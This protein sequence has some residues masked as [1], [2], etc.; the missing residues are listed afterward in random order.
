M[1]VDEEIELDGFDLPPWD[2]GEPPGGGPPRR[3][4]VGRVLP[5]LVLLFGVVALKQIALVTL[6]LL[7]APWDAWGVLLLFVGMVSGG[8]VLALLFA[9][10]WA[11][12]LR[13][14][15]GGGVSRSASQ[16]PRGPGPSARRPRA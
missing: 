15:A 5:W 6:P 14:G 16:P 11:A 9:R 12:D 7:P 3:R 8:L 2:D 13:R 4:P 1:D 10:A